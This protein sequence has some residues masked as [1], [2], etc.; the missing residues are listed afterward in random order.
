MEEHGI[1]VQVFPLP[2]E[3]QYPVAQAVQP[4][5]APLVYIT[6]PE[7]P[8]AQ[9][10]APEVPLYPSVLEH[11]IA[12]QVFPLPA[13]A[14]VFPAQAIHPPKIPLVYVTLPEYPDAHINTAFE[15]N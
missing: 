9:V 5:K 14:H 13:E 6:A 1:P 12:V 8:A 2:A 4:P 7:Y 3:A 10:Q 15:P 11:E